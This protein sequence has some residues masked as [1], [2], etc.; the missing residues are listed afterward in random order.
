MNF[1]YRSNVVLVSRGSAWLVVSP[2]GRGGF[3]THDR[4]NQAPRHTGSFGGGVTQRLA[5]SSISRVTLIAK[6][7]SESAKLQVVMI[8]G[9]SY[10]GNARM[11][12]SMILASRI[13]LATRSCLS[14]NPSTCLLSSASCCWAT[15]N[16]CCSSEPPPP[17][18]LLYG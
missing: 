2:S 7:K 6:G 4:G 9:C 5:P 10:I 14:T 11:I 16:C 18:L 3:S 8:L 12:F 1:A 15:P 13:C 17:S